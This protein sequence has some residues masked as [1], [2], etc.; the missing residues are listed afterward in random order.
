[1]TKP[2]DLKSYIRNN[3]L[4]HGLTQEQLAYALADY[5]DELS[6]IDALTI[7]RW[8]L[9]K[10][11]PSL[12]RLNSIIYYFGDQPHQILGDAGL[13]LRNLPS[14]RWL[15]KKLHEKVKIKHFIGSHPYLPKRI[16]KLDRFE[17]NSDFAR[18]SVYLVQAYIENVS[19]GLSSW[20]SG[21]LL[22]LQAHASSQAYYF[23]YHG[24]LACHCL[25][26]TLPLNVYSKICEGELEENQIDDDLL[27]QTDQASVCY[28][29]SIYS[30]R[31]DTLEQMLCLPINYLVQHPLVE[32][33]SL[34]VYRD[35]SSIWMNLLPYTVIRYGPICSNEGEGFRFQGKRYSYLLIEF[36]RNTLLSSPT[37]IN[38]LRNQSA[39]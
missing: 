8:E 28:I 14:S 19:H 6:D 27:V 17:K 12:N 22:A 35:I 25:F 7:S 13:Q 21:K 31:T 11:E 24:L 9:G 15:D 26:V 3:R 30:G 16:E 2:I 38:M 36:E 34:R 33:I 32:R 10:V 1:M 23:A 29:I 4:E 20:Q 39:E 37:V 5:S 18:E